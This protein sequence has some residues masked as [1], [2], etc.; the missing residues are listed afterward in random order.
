MAA[1]MTIILTI[2]FMSYPAPVPT[3]TLSVFPVCVKRL[4]IARLCGV[5]ICGSPLTFH[6]RKDAGTYNDKNDDGR[7]RLDGG[8]GPVPLAHALASVESAAFSE[9]ILKDELLLPKMQC[10][11]SSRAF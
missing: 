8:Q 7:K 4:A 1:A 2:V 5:R 3:G 11:V 6:W 10:Y 9:K